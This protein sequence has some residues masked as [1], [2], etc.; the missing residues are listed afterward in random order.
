V[1]FILPNEGWDTT[2]APEKDIT[3]R[4][5]NKTKPMKMAA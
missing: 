4:S 3:A 2:A 5:N 1:K